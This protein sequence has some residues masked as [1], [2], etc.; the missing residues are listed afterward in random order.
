M[1]PDDW[2]THPEPEIASPV[3]WKRFIGEACPHGRHVALVDGMHIRNTCDSDFCQGGNGFAYPDFVPEDEIWIDQC[4][5]EEEWALIVFHECM[6]AEYM[7]RD[8]MSYDKAHEKVKAEEDAFRR[9]L[10]T[11]KKSS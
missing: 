9:L 10:A 6:E 7:E 3:P 4:I 1:I 11:R 2:S 5:P 8:G